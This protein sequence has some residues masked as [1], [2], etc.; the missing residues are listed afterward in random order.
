MRGS[1]FCLL[2][3]LMFAPVVSGAA[4]DR[5]VISP[6]GATGLPFSLGILSGD[7]LYLSGSIGTKPGTRELPG[8]IEAQTRQTMDNLGSVLKSAGMD[9]SNVVQSTVFLSDSRHF[10]AFNQ[11]YRTYFS[12]DPP[13]RATVEAD[14]AIPGALA[15]IAMVAARPGLER[16]AIVPEG[17]DASQMPFSPG[18][19]AGKTLFISGILGRDAA[20]GSVPPDVASQ[21]RATLEN[22]GAILEAADMDFKDVASC[23]VF[24]EDARNFQAMNEVY[25]SFFPEDPPTRATVRARL[26]GPAFGVEI[27]CTAV[28]DP[29]RKVVVAEGARR[30]SSPFSPAIQVGDR[31]YLSG[32][33][34]RGPDGFG[35]IKDQTRRTL[36]NLQATLKAAGMDLTHVDNV[37][38]YLSD[39][40]NFEA[41]NEVYREILPTPP[42][43]RATVGAQLVVSQALVEIMMEAR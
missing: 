37:R 34:G 31:L 26:M 6:G 12:K 14:I 41:M 21:T 18:I 38:I 24:L 27:Q 4:A 11:A 17:T 5:K 36:E 7:F 8:G 10:Q 15:E 43:A 13:T 33:L 25:R 9:F 1:T 39:I 3:L 20:T 2:L 42:P 32:F 35:D 23:S 19:L 22:I 16:K 28:K 30:S 40:R 29:S